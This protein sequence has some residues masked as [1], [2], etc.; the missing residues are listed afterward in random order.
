MTSPT[1]ST[2]TSRAAAVVAGALAVLLL[3]TALGTEGLPAYARVL[4]LVACLITPLT[5]RTLHRRS[6][7]AA[8]L[9][10]IVMALLLV[11]GTVLVGAVGLPGADP[12][13]VT[14]TACGVVA[15]ALA[16]VLLL[17]LDGRDVP[18]PGPLRPPYAL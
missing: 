1:S 9:M 13:G 4:L 3:G 5:A 6:S 16:V 11:A 14:R 10:A 7:Y 2:A 18:S 12:A 8:R 15:L 17:V